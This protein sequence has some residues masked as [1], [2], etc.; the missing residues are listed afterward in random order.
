MPDSLK[1]YG[2]IVGCFYWLDFQSS[3]TNKSTV[4][5]QL[6]LDRYSQKDIGTNNSHV[7]YCLTRDRKE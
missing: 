5:L 4:E 3:A 7:V 1:L 2:P 6:T